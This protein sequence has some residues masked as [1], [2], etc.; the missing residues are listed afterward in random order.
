MLN[1]KIKA[2]IFKHYNECYPFECCGLIVGN[3]YI[4]CE[5]I[6]T[7][8]NQ[9]E[10]N[11]KDYVLAAKKGTIKAIVHSH[12]DGST[13]PSMPDKVQMNLHGKTWLIT[14]G[15]EIAEHKP[16]GFKA[17]LIG[18]EYH[19]GIMDCYTLIRDYFDRELNIRL[20]DYEREDAWWENKNSKPLYLDNFKKEGFVEVSDI[21][22]NDVILFRLGRTEHINHAAI[23]IGDGFLKSETTNKVIGDNF[24]LHHPYNADS[25]REPYTESW[26]RRTALI[27]R[28]KNL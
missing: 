26:K 11:P 23:F 20:N 17:P 16:D 15:L 9:F 14:N 6:A 10:I 2:D 5:N 8:K 18:R 13:N 1:D 22:E 21:K 7:D 12:P 24:I 19:H 25:I 4:P 28:H 3:E 27:I